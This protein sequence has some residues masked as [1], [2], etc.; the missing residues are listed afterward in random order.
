MAIV[1]P[2]FLISIVSLLV[3]LT[4][5]ALV[6]GAEIALFSLTKTDLDVEEDHPSY[7]KFRILNHLIKEPQ[8][9]L[10]TILIINN[11]VN[12]AIVPLFA[13]ISRILY[14]GLKDWKSVV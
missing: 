13:S 6:S 9:L 8:K 10:A 2:G 14:Q 12:I 4:C 11:L 1:E 5:S 3:L 7:R